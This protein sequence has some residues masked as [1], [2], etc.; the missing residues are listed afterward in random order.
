MTYDGQPIQTNFYVWDVVNVNYV[1]LAFIAKGTYI[2]KFQMSKWD[3]N[4][5]NDLAIRVYSDG[6]SPIT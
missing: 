2:M 3:T 4:A 6:S 1:Y 5:V